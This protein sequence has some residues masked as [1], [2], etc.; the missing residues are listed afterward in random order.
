MAR[1]SLYLVVGLIGGALLVNAIARD[2]GYIL[3]TWGE[4]QI[5]TSVWFALA[6]LAVASLAVIGLSRILRSTLRLPGALRRWLGLRSARGAQRRADKG[7]TA[8]FEGRW[9]TAEK[10]LRKA[11]VAEY[12]LLHPLYAALAASRRGQYERALALL[13]EA[14]ANASA[15]S[16]M[17]LTVRAEC[18][19][20]NGAIEQAE[21]VLD[22]LTGTDRAAPRVIGLRA[23]LSYLQ[24]NWSDLIQRLPEMRRGQMVSESQ[25]IGWEHEAWLRVLSGQGDVVK[26][27][28]ALWKQIPDVL[29]SDEQPHWQA[30]IQRLVAEADWESLAKLLPA[31]LERYCEPVSLEAVSALPQRQ[32]LKMKKSLQKWRDQDSNGQCHATLARIAELEGD[33]QAI[34]SLWERDSELNPSL[35][36]AL[37]WSTWLREQGEESRASELETETLARLRSDT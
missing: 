3:L 8:F 37:L 5:E 33:I 10:A 13:D 15:P 4:W 9:E 26:T 25:L 6:G 12:T 1:F 34:D 7:F 29:K 14:E 16:S 19:V 32:R 35:H 30:L 22:T 36:T 28:A 27:G 2:P 21:Q 23:H 18:H 31:R 20:A 11:A 24:G 17:I